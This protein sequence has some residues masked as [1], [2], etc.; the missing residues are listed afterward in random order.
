MCHG[1]QALS[2]ALLGMRLLASSDTQRLCS[3]LE[4]AQG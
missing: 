1:L 2:A 4:I 3:A